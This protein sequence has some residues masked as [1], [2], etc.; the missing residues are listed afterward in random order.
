MGPG[1]GNGDSSK[2]P[3][4]IIHSPCSYDPAAFSRHVLLRL[5]DY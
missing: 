3:K 1:S 4:F 2:E 5:K